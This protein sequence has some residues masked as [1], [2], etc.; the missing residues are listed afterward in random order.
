ML[1]ARQTASGLRT[2]ISQLLEA[3][4]A[5]G[6]KCFG[7]GVCMSGFCPL[8]VRLNVA[9]ALHPV[10]SNRPTSEMKKSRFGL[11]RSGLGSS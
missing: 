5:L 6:F 11:V 1:C 4:V 10:L 7:L 8:F 9:L 3:A 2:E